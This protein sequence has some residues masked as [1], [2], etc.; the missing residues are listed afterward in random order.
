MAKLAKVER[1]RHPA[2]LS[3]AARPFSRRLRL[4]FRWVM[5]RASSSAKAYCSVCPSRV[6]SPAGNS[7][8]TSEAQ[9]RTPSRVNE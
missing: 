8:V 7:A 2:A 4:A 6:P 1:K 5:S 9:R 3:A